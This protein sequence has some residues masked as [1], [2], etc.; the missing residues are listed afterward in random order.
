MAF[1]LQT[2]LRRTGQTLASWA[3][4]LGIKSVREMQDVCIS[5]GL[6]PSDD[7]VRFLAELFVP[8]KRLVQAVPAVEPA[9]A[10]V[11]TAVETDDHSLYVAPKRRRRGQADDE[12]VAKE[13]KE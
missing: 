2:Y 8:P 7:D 13:T 9:P 10:D 4:S 12:T 3:S 6:S 11:Q 1:K 5:K